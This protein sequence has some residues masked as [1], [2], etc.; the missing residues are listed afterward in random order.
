MNYTYLI[1]MIE[2]ND[3]YLSYEPHLN[4]INL[5]ELYIKQANTFEKAQDQQSQCEALKKAL[6]NLKNM[7]GIYNKKELQSELEERIKNL[8]N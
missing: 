7:Y 8:S 5:S 1:S 6:S 2:N 3:E 4:Q